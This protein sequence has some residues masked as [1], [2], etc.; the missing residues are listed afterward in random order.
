MQQVFINNLEYKGRN[1]ILHLKALLAES[2]HQGK[3]RRKLLQME[4]GR[5]AETMDYPIIPNTLKLLGNLTFVG[6]NG[7]LMMVSEN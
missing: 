3:L 6:E 7:M 4:A 1:S 5:N 2:S